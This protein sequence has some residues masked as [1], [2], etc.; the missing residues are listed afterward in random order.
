MVA[1]WLCIINLYTIPT[2][3]KKPNLINQYDRQ[4]AEQPAL[5]QE[6]VSR[7]KKDSI[8]KHESVQVFDMLGGGANV[9]VDLDATIPTRFVQEVHFTEMEWKGSFPPYLQRLWDEFIFD[10][11]ARK[12]RYIILFK[13]SYFYLGKASNKAEGIELNHFIHAYYVPLAE[14]EKYII[15]KIKAANS[16]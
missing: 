13:S 9:L 16:Q 7:L 1:C 2:I 4:V 14:A 6:I 3:F 15:Y 11:Y 12:P 8:Q 5:I 10:L